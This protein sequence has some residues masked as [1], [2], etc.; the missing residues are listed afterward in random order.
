MLIRALAFLSVMAG[1]I[2]QANQGEGS[3]RRSKVLVLSIM[4]EVN[5]NYTNGS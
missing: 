5:S 3:R 4:C 1:S 2:P